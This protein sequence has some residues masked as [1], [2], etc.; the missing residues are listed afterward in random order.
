MSTKRSENLL[1]YDFLNVSAVSD[2]L[3]VSVNAYEN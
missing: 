2:F 3:N 1:N